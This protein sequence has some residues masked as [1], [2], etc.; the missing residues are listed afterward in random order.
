MRFSMVV[1]P[2]VAPVGAPVGAPVVGPM[3][4]AG[5]TPKP[6]PGLAM[7]MDSVLTISSVL[8][9]GVVMDPAT[10]MGMEVDHGPERGRTSL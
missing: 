10:I 1:D 4:S 2:V 7:A 3:M 6:F 8:V 5:P 9:T